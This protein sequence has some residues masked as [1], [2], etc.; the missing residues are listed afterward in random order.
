MK[1]KNIRVYLNFKED[2]YN[3]FDV[4]VEYETEKGKRK[5]GFNNIVD[6][7][8]CNS[9]EEFFK[10]LDR[11]IDIGKENIKEFIKKEEGGA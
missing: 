6:S 3:Y 2:D 5:C 10:L 9:M 11:G 4:R 1:L 8:N 7:L